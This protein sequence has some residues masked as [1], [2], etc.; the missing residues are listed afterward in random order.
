MRKFAFAAILAAYTSI[1]AVE[2]NA[3]FIN[4]A[5]TLQGSGLSQIA[6]IPP[7]PTAVLLQPTITFAAVLAL[8]APWWYAR[9]HA[10]RTAGRAK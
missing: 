7:A 2:A 9:S 6:N 1:V 5:F 3:A 4:G 8:L 10:A